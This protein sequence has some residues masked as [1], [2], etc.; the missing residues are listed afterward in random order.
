MRTLFVSSGLFLLLL[1]FGLRAE[2]SQFTPLEWQQT[3][4]RAPHSDLRGQRKH[5]TWSRDRNGDFIDDRIPRRF[6]P[7]QRVDIIV[8]LNQCVPPE[9]VVRRFSRYGRISHIGRFITYVIIE[10]VRFEE[11]SQ[12]ARMDDVAMIEWQSGGHP[13]NDVS[14]RAVQSRKST[15]YSPSTAEDVNITGNGVTIAILDSGVDETHKALAGKFVAGFDALKFVDD[16]NAPNGIDDDCE[17]STSDPQCEPWSGSNP[18]AATYHGTHVAATALGNDLTCP[19]PDE[20]GV[21]DCTGT[22]ASAKLVDIKVC[23]EGCEEEDLA[24]GLEWLAV[25]AEAKG[26]RVANLSLAFCDA[27]TSTY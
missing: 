24:E 17:V 21:V 9:M 14:T 18:T 8:D 3:V 19:S 10:D 1:L 25:H 23:D 13:A 5:T 22:A 12:L 2:A 16:P 4:E 6:K 20:P 11:L 27:D 26:I 7:G 15:P